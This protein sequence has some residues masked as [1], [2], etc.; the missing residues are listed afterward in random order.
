MSRPL[1]LILKLGNYIGDDQFN[2]AY[3]PPGCLLGRS[4][5]SSLRALEASGA[6]LL[7]YSIGVGLYLLGRSSASKLPGLIGLQ[8][9]GGED[10][11][12]VGEASG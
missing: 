6:R 7:S 5:Q 12:V 9:G 11:I 4:S 2:P 1:K 3:I 8:G 10:F